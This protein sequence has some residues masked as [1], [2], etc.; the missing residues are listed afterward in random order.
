MEKYKQQGLL[1][2]KI[3]KKRMLKNTMEKAMKKLFK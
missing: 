2:L 3:N 1:K